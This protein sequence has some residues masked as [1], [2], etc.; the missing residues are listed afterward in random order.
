MAFLLSLPFA[1]SLFQCGTG[2]VGIGIKFTEENCEFKDENFE[3]IAT[4]QSFRYQLQNIATETA[5]PLPSTKSRN[6]NFTVQIPIKP[7]SQFQ[8]IW[9]GYE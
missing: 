1:V 5:T 6:S 9:G 7:K 4:Y 8:C 3:Y 2:N